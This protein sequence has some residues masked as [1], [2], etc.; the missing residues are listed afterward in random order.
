LGALLNKIFALC[1][2]TYLADE[3]F[4]TE[5]SGWGHIAFKFETLLNIIILYQT[6]TCLGLDSAVAGL[7]TSLSC[8]PYCGCC[9]C[10]PTADDV[11]TA[12]VVEVSLYK[13][14]DG[15]SMELHRFSA[16]EKTRSYTWHLRSSGQTFASDLFRYR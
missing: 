15:R 11:A 7:G 4:C 9:R 1:A 14:G 10:E 12:G 2:K 8:R 6:C 3:C 5:V 16:D 13:S